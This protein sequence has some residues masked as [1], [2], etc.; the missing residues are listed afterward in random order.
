M[1]NTTLA[2]ILTFVLLILA[3]ILLPGPLF[4]RLVALIRENGS[5][6]EAVK[7]AVEQVQTTLSE[8]TANASNPSAMTDTR[9]TQE[10][11]GTPSMGTTK[12]TKTQKNSSE[13]SSSVS[14]T[15]NPPSSNTTP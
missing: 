7:Q 12:T 1:D 5:K 15:S 3:L 10:L 2:I 11:A 9:S 8:G 13:S 6:V 4:I 14:T